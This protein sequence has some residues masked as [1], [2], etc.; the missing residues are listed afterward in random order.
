MA[1]RETP[2]PA[3]AAQPVLAAL[4]A[5]PDVPIR[6]QV[7]SP[8]RY[9][10]GKRRLVPYLAALLRENELQPGL[11]VEPFAGGA[12][13]ALELAALGIVKRIA[14]ADLDP[15][16]ASFWNTVFYD[17]DWL[18][19]RIE[20]IDVTLA[21]W[22][23]LKHTKAQSQ[24]WQALACLFLNRTSFNGALHRSAGPIGGRAQTSEYDLACRFP[25]QR[26]V[27]RL[28]A[29]E[30]LA[31]DGKVAW[32]R[33]LSAENAIRDARREA[34]EAG[35]TTFFYLDPPFWAKSSHL[36]RYGFV[37]FHHEELAE[38]LRW[39]REP[40]L[41]SYDLA[42]E[43][44]ELYEKHDVRRANVELLYTGARRAGYEELVITNQSGLPSDTKLWHTKAE[45]KQRRRAASRP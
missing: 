25:R 17:C 20:T 28:R 27:R 23:R 33:C 38:V 3:R 12:S 41:L 13:V 43:V 1:D 24:R 35:E 37:D 16:V 6:R 29:C 4:P 18:C 31:K 14:L 2:Q 22:D 39:L 5:K 9:P 44:V 34:T 19:R 32:V 8:L 11:F 7:L 30:Q 42:D 26:L 21:T 45:W 15:W 10:G 40:W 36:Y